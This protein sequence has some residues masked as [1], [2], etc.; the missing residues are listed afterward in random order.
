MYQITNNWLGGE[1]CKNGDYLSSCSLKLVWLY[2]EVPHEAL[3][4]TNCDNVMA[5][6]S[7][8]NIWVLGYPFSPILESTILPLGYGFSSSLDKSYPTFTNLPYSK[9]WKRGLQGPFTMDV[10]ASQWPTKP[11]P[12][13]T[14][15]KLLTNLIITPPK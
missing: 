8:L 10:I 5:I 14:S 9:V 13:A 1:N 12:K 6:Y 15:S 7:K 11:L 3:C 2:C 4:N